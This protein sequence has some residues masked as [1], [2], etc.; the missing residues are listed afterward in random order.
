MTVPS[1]SSEL[2][3]GSLHF[4]L[5]VYSIVTPSSMLPHVRSTCSGIRPLVGGP[6]KFPQNHMTGHASR[7]CATGATQLL[8][9]P[10]APTLNC[11]ACSLPKVEPNIGYDLTSD[12]VLSSSIS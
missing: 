7:A 10:L 3:H 12:L 9:D 6:H 5:H 1:F 11:C 8:Q 4:E 2:A